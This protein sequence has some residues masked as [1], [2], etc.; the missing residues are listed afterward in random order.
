MMKRQVSYL[1]RLVDD[2]L[3][4]S[5]I[6]RGK[7][8]IKKEVVD[9]AAVV[10][11][12][13]ET[14]KPL[15]ETRGHHIS[16]EYPPELLPIEVDP[17]RLTQAVSNLINNAAHYTDP[18]GLIE[19][20]TQG[21]ENEAILRVRDNGRGISA[22]MLPKVFDLF[23]QVRDNPG[24]SEGGLGI[25]LALV[26]DLVQLHGGRVEAH[27]DG[28]GLGSEFVIR[29][30]LATSVP[31]T[32]F[33]RASIKPLSSDVLRILIIEDNE[34]VA[35]SLAMLLQTFGGTVEIARSG[36]RALQ[37]SRRFSLTL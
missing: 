18:G 5:R 34:D 3:E 7:I 23:T 28:L 13:I 17:V 25:G 36:P 11:N 2:L 1:V 32:N 6:N 9:C 8:E 12:A 19:I 33:E 35:N 16:V 37:R 4:I 24:D 27:S 15:I 20:A 29:L 21:S 30:P 10:N 22:D 31:P 26:R 14:C